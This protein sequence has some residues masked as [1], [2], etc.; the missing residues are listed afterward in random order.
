M[1]GVAFKNDWRACDDNR[2]AL[3]AHERAVVL[4]DSA[5]D[6]RDWVSGIIRQA[7]GTARAVESVSAL[8]NDVLASCH[9]VALVAV[10]GASTPDH[11][12][13]GIIAHCKSAGLKVIA[14]EH[15]VEQWSLGSKCQSLVAGALHLL[16]S[17]SERFPAELKALLE[18]EFI[19]QPGQ[20]QEQ[21][22]IRELM[23]RHGLVGDSPALRGC[24]R[25][26]VRFS[27]LSDVPVLITGES[28]TGKELVARAIYKMDAKRNK[29]RFLAINC[30]AITSSLME[31]EF[32]G[33]RRGAFT[34]AERDRK[35][36]IR[37]TEGGVLFLD[38]IGELELRL[39]A[40]L[41]R[42]LQEN[43]VLGLGDEQEMAVN[44]RFIVAT[45]RNLEQMAA[46]GRFRADLLHR[47]RALLIH[48]PPLRDRPADLPAL[49]EHFV[50]K[51]HGLVTRPHVE[52]S[53][54]FLQAVG[55]VDLTGNVRQLENVVRQSLINH[56]GSGALDLKD[57][58]L[59]VLRRIS[60]R[61]QTGASGQYSST[62][63]PLAPLRQHPQLEMSELVRRILDNQGWNLS[64]ALRECERNLVEVALQ[65]T[66]GNQSQA[67]LLLGITA[68]SVYNIL[69]RS[70]L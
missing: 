8:D 64:G 7:G 35:G 26:A 63:E 9:D 28:G 5:R 17:A 16:D 23:R 10:A 34:G 2:S 61:R 70:R 58:P 54:N 45:N 32:F 52:V 29:H 18:Q 46:E 30:A 15:G 31:S 57:L 12:V 41:L 33:H 22:Q 47:L 48:I 56:Q 67:A 60:E 50:R 59:D 51:H 24:F 14:Y 62:L 42:V 6:R 19:G 3:L 53:Q 38:E 68:R 66:K 55:Q 65:H 39:Q 43:C 11:P 49:V 36:F 25:S 21:Q 69:R 1:E 44:V 20:Q 37:A 13:W 40:K 27:E 4:C